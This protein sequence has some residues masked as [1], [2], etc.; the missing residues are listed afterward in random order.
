MSPS[1]RPLGQPSTL[2]AALA[3]IAYLEQQLDLARRVV[4]DRTGHDLATMMEFAGR[5][6]GGTTGSSSS[7][8]KNAAAAATA[9]SSG[10]TATDTPSTQPLGVPPAPTATAP[11]PYAPSPAPEPQEEQEQEEPHD[12]SPLVLRAIQLRKDLHSGRVE[13]DKG[14]DELQSI[15]G[16][17][18]ERM[19]E[20][21]RET[22]RRWAGL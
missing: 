17:G 9:P 21:Q 5:T 18:G 11:A 22:V 8:L 1:S 14:E 2:E 20:E 16:A 3:R 12:I 13:E 6:A 10:S 7:S 19:S 15:V 4:R